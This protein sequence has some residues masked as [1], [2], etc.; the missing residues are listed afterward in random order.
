MEGKSPGIGLDVLD[1][2]NLSAIGS[3]IG[4]GGTGGGVGERSARLSLGLSRE[5]DRERAIILK[6]E[7]FFP[8]VLFP[9]ECAWAS[10]SPVVGL[11]GRVRVFLLF[12]CLERPRFVVVVESVRYPSRVVVS[13]SLTEDSGNKDALMVA[14]KASGSSIVVNEGMSVEGLGI[15]SPFFTVVITSDP[16]FLLSGLS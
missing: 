9:E 6:N 14:R 2:A 7:R 13:S 11:D 10:S 8:R 3:M 5:A 12:G 1:R 4:I 15:S 16:V